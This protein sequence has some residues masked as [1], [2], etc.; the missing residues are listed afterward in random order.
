MESIRLE[1]RTGRDE[2]RPTKGVGTTVPLPVETSR[3]DSETT[4][5]H[6]LERVPSTRYFERTH[7]A[8]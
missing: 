5:Y 2:C 3:D 4:Y 8:V 6:L 1:Q 7:R